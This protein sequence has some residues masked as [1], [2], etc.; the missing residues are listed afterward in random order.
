MTG[1]GKVAINGHTYNIVIV[2]FINSLGG[3]D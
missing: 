2:D 1:P 3:S